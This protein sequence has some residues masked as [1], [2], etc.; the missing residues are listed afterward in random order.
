MHL[1]LDLA[2]RAKFGPDVEW[3]APA[4]DAAA[5]FG[6]AAADRAADA[7]AASAGS[8]AAGAARGPGASSAFTASPAADAART[9]AAAAAA[10]AS[11]ADVKQDMYAVDAARAY[12]FYPAI[13][14]YWPGLPDGALQA[15]YAGVSYWAFRGAD[16]ASLSDMNV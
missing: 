14:E 2:G 16:L 7:A 9:L 15:A 6:A 8:T 13:R 4:G 5:A 11:S 12:V 3:L 10:T 1:T